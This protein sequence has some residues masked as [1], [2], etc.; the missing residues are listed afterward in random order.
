MSFCYVFRCVYGEG[1]VV[2]FV[3]CL[4][5]GADRGSW[6]EERVGIVGLVVIIES[7]GVG[8]A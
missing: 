8:G 4:F 5:F 1:G 2:F 3:F 7:V 6:S